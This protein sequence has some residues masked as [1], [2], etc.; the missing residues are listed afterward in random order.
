MVPP[1]RKLASHPG[2]ILDPPLT[3]MPSVRSSLIGTHSLWHH[4]WEIQE[5]IL[6]FYSKKTVYS[7]FQEIYNF[8]MRFSPIFHIVAFAPFLINNYIS[9]T[10]CKY[11]STIVSCYVLSL[12]TKWSVGIFIVI[13]G[14]CGVSL[15]I[16]LGCPEVSGK[17]SGSFMIIRWPIK[18]FVY[19]WHH[20]VYKWRHKPANWHHVRMLCIYL[21]LYVRT[22]T[23]FHTKLRTQNVNHNCRIR[24][25]CYC[26]FSD[27]SI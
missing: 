13:G 1:P 14:S 21:L 5:F 26:G 25:C 23:R 22:H 17:H 11:P 3:V 2:K 19:Q 4:I 9:V 10:F 27:R 7:E 8:I 6:S 12:W 16:D 15:V 20:L 18:N 24:S